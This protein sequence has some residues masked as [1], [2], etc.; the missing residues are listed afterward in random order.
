MLEALNN[1]TQNIIIAVIISIIIEM[2]LP[3]NSNKKYVKVVTG[4]YIL[5]II[6]SPIFSLK[7][8]DG[9]EEIE[10]LLINDNAVSTSANVDIAN[11]YILS[12]E[13]SLKAQIEEQGYN[14]EEVKLYITKDYSDIAKIEIKMKAGATYDKNKIIEIIKSS[15]EIDKNNIV[16]G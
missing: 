4:L 10:K 16:F 8:E 5:Y 13:N 6:V 11:T 2:I 7:S 14:V 3:D 15:Y 1:W 9:I 12:L